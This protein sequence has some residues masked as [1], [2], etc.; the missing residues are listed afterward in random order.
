ME[1]LA[2]LSA[3]E[4]LTWRGVACCGWPSLRRLVRIGTASWPLMKVT[5]ISASA[6]EAMPLL[7]ILG[8]VKMG[9]L[10]V[11]SVRGGKRGFMDRSLRK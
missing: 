10:R 2:K 4:L 6:A 5:P 1:S 8:T 11:V 3:V 7:K 9:P